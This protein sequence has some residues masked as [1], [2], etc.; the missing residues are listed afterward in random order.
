M[1]MVAWPHAPMEINCYTALILYFLF[2]AKHYPIPIT[3]IPHGN[4]EDQ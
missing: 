2:V 3:S 1:G 4:P